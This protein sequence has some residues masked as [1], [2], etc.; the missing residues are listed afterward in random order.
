M[1]NNKGTLMKKQILMTAILC[2]AQGATAM[3]RPN[4]VRIQFDLGPN[5]SAEE[6]EFLRSVAAAFQSQDYAEVTRLSSTR[7]NT[8]RANLNPLDKALLDAASEQDYNKVIKYLDEGANINAQDANGNTSLN[9]IIQKDI[10]HSILFQTMKA[11]D[12][13][14]IDTHDKK[15]SRKLIRLLLDKEANVATPNNVGDTSLMTAALGGD[16]PTVE[17]L[18]SYIPLA[19]Q[20]ILKSTRLALTKKTKINPVLPKDRQQMIL[21]KISTELANEQFE[22][23]ISVIKM[24][25]KDSFTAQDIASM[26]EHPAIASL[27][28][29]NNPESFK[30]IHQLI[31]NNIKRIMQRF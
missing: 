20:Q 18:L 13:N 9:L 6:I 17:L 24:E 8:S 16:K 14:A 10:A 19:K 2:L 26:H 25:N 28:D 29:L 12:A 23:A 3:D 11:L 30:R 15:A 4:R 22:N 1:L 7:L 31:E 21:K 5:A 27:L